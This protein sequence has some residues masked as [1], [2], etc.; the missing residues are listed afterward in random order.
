MLNFIFP[1]LFAAFGIYFLILSKSKKNYK[2]LVDNNGEEFANKVNK[3]GKI[4]SYLLL[5]CSLLWIIL[6]W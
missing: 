1:S 2:K 3:Y 5:A 4:G 6:F